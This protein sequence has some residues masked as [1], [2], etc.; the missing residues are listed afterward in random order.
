M[1]E[2]WYFNLLSSNEAPLTVLESFKKSRSPK[3]V[4]EGRMLTE[5]ARNV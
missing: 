5:I 3:P 1:F 4:E 2:K